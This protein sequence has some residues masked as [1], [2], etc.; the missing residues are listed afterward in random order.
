M[1]QDENGQAVY[2]ELISKGSINL[3][4][5]DKECTGMND[6]SLS[7]QYYARGKGVPKPSS[8]SM[9]LTPTAKSATQTSATASET[10]TASSSKAA[11]PPNGNDKSSAKHQV[12]LKCTFH[13]GMVLVALFGLLL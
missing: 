6:T 8:T 10:P 7:E 1:L 4:G 2:E 5:S 11:A 9:S 13:V 12:S 3:I